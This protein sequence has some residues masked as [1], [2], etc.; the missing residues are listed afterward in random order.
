MMQKATAFPA[1]GDLYFCNSKKI[2]FVLHRLS[3]GSYLP[4]LITANKKSYKS[5]KTHYNVYLNQ[6]A[7]SSLKVMRNGMI[8]QKFHW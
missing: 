8:L 6:Q 4:P 3:Y 1:C 2:P 5:K 7:V